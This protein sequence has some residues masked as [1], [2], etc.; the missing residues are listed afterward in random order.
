MI[1]ACLSAESKTTFG[2]R[3]LTSAFAFL[4]N[5]VGV[6]RL[7]ILA[8]GD[9]PVLGRSSYRAV[10]ALRM[11]TLSLRLIRLGHPDLPLEVIY[12][13]LVDPPDVTQLG[14]SIGVPSCANLRIVGMLTARDD[15]LAPRDGTEVGVACRREKRGILEAVLRLRLREP[16]APGTVKEPDVVVHAHVRF[17]LGHSAKA[18]Q[19]VLPYKCKSALTSSQRKRMGQ[20]SQ[21][22]I[23]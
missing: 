14:P 22:S 1:S 13:D 18:D 15:Q 2:T 16:L 7:G 17:Q 9:D 12:I 10:G 11:K 23:V 3:Q 6:S 8:R 19:L 20:D 21:T 5:R 4:V